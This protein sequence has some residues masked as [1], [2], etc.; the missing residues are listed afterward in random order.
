MMRVKKH[1]KKNNYINN[2]NSSS[3]GSCSIGR[4]GA[5]RDE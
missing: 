4:K 3:I 5:Q 1:K 2:N